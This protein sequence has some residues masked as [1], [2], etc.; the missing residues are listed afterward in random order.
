MVPVTGT[1]PLI[2]NVIAADAAP[3]VSIVSQPPF[4]A[5]EVPT[6]VNRPL[7]GPLA[8]PVIENVTLEHELNSPSGSPL[9]MVPSSVAVT[10]TPLRLCAERGSAARSRTP[11]H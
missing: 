10:L 1:G 7:I 2:W 5:N 6:A 4:A 8:V 9:T 11:A 3:P